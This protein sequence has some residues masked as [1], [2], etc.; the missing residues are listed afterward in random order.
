MT[1]GGHTPRLAV[2]DINWEV[3][4]AGLLAIGRDAYLLGPKLTE[5]QSFEEEE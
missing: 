3:G 4:G 5:I 1:V 2:A